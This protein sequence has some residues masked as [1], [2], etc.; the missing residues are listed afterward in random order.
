MGKIP[1]TEYWAILYARAQ[2]YGG[3]DWVFEL[4]VSGYPLY[5]SKCEFI[6]LCL[7]FDAF[8]I[9]NDFYTLG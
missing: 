3:A 2:W 1:P 9:K 6:I 8:M 4:K 5:P 7:K